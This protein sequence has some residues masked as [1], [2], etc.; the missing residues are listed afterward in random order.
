MENPKPRLARW[1]MDIQAYAF[2]V[3]YAPGNGKWMAVPDAL[4]RDTA[5]SDLK[6]CGHCFELVG[7]IEED[8]EWSAAD[9]RVGQE[10]KLRDLKAAGKKK[11]RVQNE[12][13]LF[14]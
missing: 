5:D 7:E 11:E 1:P 10:T 12:E 14:S 9:W 6:L 13:G 3:V 4:W 8:L 2:A